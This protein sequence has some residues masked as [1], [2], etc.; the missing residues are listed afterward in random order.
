MCDQG[1]DV[2]NVIIKNDVKISK[3]QNFEISTSFFDAFFTVEPKVLTTGPKL[4]TDQGWPL[5]LTYLYESASTI[6]SG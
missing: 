5:L 4:M 6:N 2:T 3:L 1:W